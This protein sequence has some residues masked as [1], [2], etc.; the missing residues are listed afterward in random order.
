MQHLVKVVHKGYQYKANEQ[1]KARLLTSGHS[2][3]II[4]STV[5]YTPHWDFLSLLLGYSLGVCN[6]PHTVIVPNVAQLSVTGATL[7][8]AKQ[9]DCARLC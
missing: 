6:Q 8:L 1:C 2:Q 3:A 7:C 4:R 5:V 9:G